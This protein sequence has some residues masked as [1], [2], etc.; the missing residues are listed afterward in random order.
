VLSLSERLRADGIYTILDRYVEKG[1]PPEG[2][3]RWMMNGLG[4]AT[5]IMCVCTETYQR[6]FLGQEAPDIGKGVDWEG[7]LITQNLYDARSRNNK[8]IPVLF[9]HFDKAYIIEPLRS[10]T[11]YILDSEANYQALYD[12]LLEQAGVEPGV[13][14]ELKRKPRAT[15]QSLAFGSDQNVFQS[16]ISRI[17]KYAPAELIGREVETKLLNDAWNQAVN[18]EAKRPH[19]LTFV[20]LGGEGKTSLVAKWAADLAHSD[21]PGCEAVFAWSF[22][23]QGTHDAA[24]SDLFLKE[25]LSFFGDAE[26]AESSRGSYDKGKRLA[27]LVGEKQALLILDGVEPLQYAPTSPMPGELKDVGL[28]TLLKGL[29]A[30]SH[31]LCVVTTRYSIPDLRAYW[32]TNAPEITLARLS[33]SAG[34]S[35]LRS[36]GVKGL[37]QEFEKLV[38]DVK[39]HALSLNLLGSYLRDAHAG[40]IRKRDLVKL[41]EADDEE[42]GGHA[43]RV[44]DAYVQWFEQDEEN[45][46]ESNRGQRAL[47][48]LRLMGLFDRPASA[49]C[50]FALLKAPTIPNLTELL[51]EKKEA[52]RNTALT[53][54]VDAKLL[55]V[56]RDASGTLLSLDTHPL[57]REYFAKYLREQHPVSWR[58]AHRR[59]YKHLISTTNEGDQPTLEA[60][61][62]LY[63]AVAHGCLAGM[64]QEVC[65][66][67]FLYRI[68]RGQETYSVRKLGAFGSDLGAVACFF[69]QPWGR[70]S[71]ALTEDFQAWLLGEAAYRLRAL[72]RLAE[73]REPMRTGLEMRI[74]HQSW[75]NA[76]RSTSNLSE[77]ELTLGDL[78]G[79]EKSSEQSVRYADLS[80]DFFLAVDSRSAHADALHQAGD[81]S[82]AEAF[83]IE[84]ESRQ[85]KRHSGYPMLY[86]VHGFKY[87][88]L[89]LSAPERAAWLAFLTCYASGRGIEGATGQNSGDTLP[90]TKVLREVSVLA[91]QTLEWSDKNDMDI[92]SGALDHLTLG[93]AALYTAM[94]LQSERPN[95][96]TDISAAVDGLRRAGNQQYFPLG[97][98]TRALLCSRKGNFEEAE[99]DLDEA[100]DLAERGPMPLYMADIHMHRAR[101]FFREAHYPWVSPQADLA[102]ARRLIEKHG[103]WR[104]KEELEDAEAAILVKRV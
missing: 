92:I 61:Q 3:P 32:Q 29:S 104:R 7:A 73:A 83:F 36:L 20:A 12:V 17:I 43:F 41:E 67:V 8:F 54:L 34:V 93:R 79:A 68:Q 45:K 53:R 60:L 28:V 74:K 76:A 1:S 65:G 48:L 69:E 97:L 51:I 27:Q 90:H 38:E 95:L 58:M 78:I 98:L 84:A 39:G 19:V 72:G 57:L 49:D 31:G 44:V 30:N 24:S 42:Q 22:Y 15:G 37:Q 75:N 50:F 101:L 10:Q 47:A 82:A 99:A 91:A 46:G 85:A 14:G 26:L 80:G 52:S 5:H 55:T 13:V 88:D 11:H 23:S 64:Q 4:E 25:A 86:S 102:E 62:P 16:D 21:W 6:R 96:E 56:N 71:T 100:W 81:H 33:N 70:V 63:Q 89:L 94:L 66:K 59:I 35:L 77:L 2:W 9:A 18:G 40:D 87:C 103:Y